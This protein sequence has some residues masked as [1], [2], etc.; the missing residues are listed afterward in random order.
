MNTLAQRIAAWM[1]GASCT[2]AAVAHDSPEHEIERLTTWM[3]KR[4]KTS[5]YLLQRATEY[6]AWGKLDLAEVD[7]QDAIQRDPDLIPAR[8]DLSRLYLSMGKVTNALDA[9]CLA[10]QRVADP[11]AQSPLQMVCAQIH[12]ARGDYAQAL[13]ACNVAFRGKPTELDWY[14]TRSRIQFLLHQ[15]EARIQGLKDGLAL[16]GSF[17]LETEGIEAL[18][19]AG[20]CTEALPAIETQ[21]QGVRWQSSWLIR[22]ARARLGLG[23][24][25][26]AHQDLQAALSEIEQRLD[27]GHPDLTLRVDRGIALALLGNLDQAR[28]ELKA[29]KGQMDDDGLVWRLEEMVK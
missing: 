20:R 12:L 24:S 14:L 2:L 27:P 26:E 10:L 3:A 4:G 7:L 17:V 9:V 23:Q 22:R 18:L 19:D 25:R 8:L 6:R 28:Q 1:V 29:V 16:T 21:L 11:T 5:S 15:H 13:A